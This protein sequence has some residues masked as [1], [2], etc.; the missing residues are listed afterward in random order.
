MKLEQ[1]TEQMKN[2]NLI[3]GACSVG[4]VKG[5]EVGRG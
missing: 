5:R 3:G 2:Y 4:L 1:L